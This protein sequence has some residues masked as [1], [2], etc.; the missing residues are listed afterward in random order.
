MSLLPPKN[1]ICLYPFWFSQKSWHESDA[2]WHKMWDITTI[3]CL[4][5]SK[6]YQRSSL[7]IG[8]NFDTIPSGQLHHPAYVISPVGFIML[9]QSFYRNVIFNAILLNLQVACFLSLNCVAFTN[10]YFV[11]VM[12]FV[13]ILTCK[14]VTHK[15]LVCNYFT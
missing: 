1:N 7:V 5:N 8:S 14:N 10:V 2:L 12:L 4:K 3:L 11:I 6:T 9:T 15:N 13:H